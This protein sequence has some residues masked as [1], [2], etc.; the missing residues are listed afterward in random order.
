MGGQTLF[1]SLRSWCILSA[2][3]RPSIELLDQPKNNI[4]RARR[5]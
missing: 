2:T 4:A 1:A 5:Q 3:G